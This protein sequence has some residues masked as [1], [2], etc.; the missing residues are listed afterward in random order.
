MRYSWSAQPLVRALRIRDALRATVA[1]RPTVWLSTHGVRSV[2]SGARPA[3]SSM[4]RV[5]STLLDAI[6]FDIGGTIVKEGEPTTPIGDLVPVLLPCVVADLAFL[7]RRVRIGAAT[8]T[9]VMKEPAV[10][11]L[12]DAAGIGRYFEVIVTSCDVGAAKP[13]PASLIAVSTRMKLA[14]PGRILYVGDRDTDEIAARVAGFHF[15]YV[16]T[17]GIRESVVRWV[18]GQL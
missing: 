13:D 3:I 6:I 8:N 16:H 10:R 14:D 11:S 5:I 1:S 2:R 12:L 7:S 18:D 15:T 9:F 17:G 4:T